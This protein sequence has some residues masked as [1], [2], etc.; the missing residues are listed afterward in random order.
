MNL[1]SIAQTLKPN[2][3]S[4][5]YA[6]FLA[7]NAAGVWGGVF[8]F[9]PFE[10]QTPE[11]LLWFFLAQALTYSATYLANAAGAYFLPG[12][13]RRFLVKLTSAPYFLGWCC[14]IAAIYLDALAL[15]LVVC[16]GALLGLGSAGFYMLWQRLFASQGSDEG[17]RDLVVGTAY[18]SVVYFALY[19][20]PQAITAF[21][22]PVVFLPLFGLCIL[23]RSREIDRNQPMFEDVPRE[24][25]KVYRRVV[26][27]YWRSA[28]CIGAVA[29]C[30][31]IVRSLAIG[32]ASAG[33]FVNA[34]SMAGSLVAALV[35]LALWRAKGLRL[36][37]ARA[38]R[39]LFPF[40]I[41]SFVLLP[42]APAEYGRW[43]AALLYALYS[44]AVM[45]M[46]VQCA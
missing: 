9:L 7:V 12:Q 10:F 30:A 15:P 21:L 19:L 40:I 34:L 1:R 14:L 11:I 8:P 17:D 27:D 32:E 4:A 36:S 46:M 39:L 18:A 43:L 29:F 3:A 28:L 6:L 13:T 42:F 23:I 41:T 45:L 16:G 22:I 31:G 44:A 24:H 33:T 38:Y 37:V 5:G 25:P 35:V 20:I 2:T 26:H